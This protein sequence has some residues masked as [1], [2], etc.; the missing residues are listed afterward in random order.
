MRWGFS[1]SESTLPEYANGPQLLPHLH[2]GLRHSGRRRR[3]GGDPR[4]RRSGPPVLA[5][6][7]LPEGTRTAIAAP[8]PGPTRTSADAGGRPATGHRVGSLSRRSGNAVEEHH[9]PPRAAIGRVLLQHHGKRR[10]PD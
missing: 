4:P 1:K 6:L 3:G 10:I 8:S 5:G 2:F 7:Y 9:R